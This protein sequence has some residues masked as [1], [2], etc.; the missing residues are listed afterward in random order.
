M[1]QWNQASSFEMRQW[2]KVHTH[3]IKVC[4]EQTKRRSVQG[5]Q[6]IR[7]WMTPSGINNKES[8][9]INQN[10]NR[11]HI[12]RKTQ[13]QAII[14]WSITLNVRFLFNFCRHPVGNLFFS[15]LFTHQYIGTALTNIYLNEIPSRLGQ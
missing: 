3:H 13:K 8:T 12:T 6:D 15:D 5:V 2:L 7:K 9:Q 10:I 1:C 4:L 11:T 14:K